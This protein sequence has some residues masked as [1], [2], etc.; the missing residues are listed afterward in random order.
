RLLS[1]NPGGLVVSEYESR[2]YFRGG[3]APQ[4][5]GY[6]QL[7]SPE[8]LNEYRRKGYSGSERIGQT[9]VEQWAED[10]LAGEHGG[11]LR[12]VSPTGQIL[13]TLGQSAP[14]PADSIYLTI[15]S[16]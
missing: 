14:K 16:N 5:V 13:S 11:T 2:Y 15:D 10:Y 1:I 7:I 9:G 8:Q 4:A 6:T 12:V 3:L